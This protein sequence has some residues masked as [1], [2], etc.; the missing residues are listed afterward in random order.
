[1]SLGLRG[2]QEFDRRTGVDSWGRPVG[3]RRSGWF[4][5]GCQHAPRAVGFLIDGKRRLRCGRSCEW[6]CGNGSCGR[7]G[8]GRNHCLW[9][10]GGLCAEHRGRDRPSDHWN[11]SG[12]KRRLTIQ[13]H[14]GP[15]HPPYRR[16]PGWGRHWYERCDLGHPGLGPSRPGFRD[17]LS[18]VSPFGGPVDDPLSAGRPSL[19]LGCARRE[20]GKNRQHDWQQGWRA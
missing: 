19:S 5:G 17:R 7:R 10:R 11:S 16:R 13:R 15:P 12:D 20:R 18:S 1:M 2:R 9:G 3:P 6:S 4:L 8:G 14:A